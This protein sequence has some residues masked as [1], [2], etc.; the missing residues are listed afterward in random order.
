MHLTCA[1]WGLACSSVG[2]GPGKRLS[3]AGWHERS[4]AAPTTWFTATFISSLVWCSLLLGWRVFGAALPS[5]TTKA[6]AT[7]RPSGAGSIVGS[8]VAYWRQLQPISLLHQ[9]RYSTRCGGQIGV[10]IRIAA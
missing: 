9:R 5:S 10:R 1:P 8:H 4:V 2:S 7:H 3:S 6:T